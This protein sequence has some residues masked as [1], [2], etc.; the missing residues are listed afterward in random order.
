MN[1]NETIDQLRTMQAQ[2]V[3]GKPFFGDTATMLA[4]CQQAINHVLN[5]IAED[6]RKFWLMG[7]MTGSYEKLTFAASLLWER[8]Q[9]VIKGEFRP[10]EKKWERYCAEKDQQDRLLTH[11]RDHDITAP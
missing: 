6:P 8:D 2:I 5:A 1:V 4:A 11:C 10:E 9:D 7:D 3:H